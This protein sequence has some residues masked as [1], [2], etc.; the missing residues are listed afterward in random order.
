[1]SIPPNSWRR[2]LATVLGRPTSKERKVFEIQLLLLFILC[3]VLYLGFPGTRELR[4]IAEEKQLETIILGWD[5]VAWFVWLGA[6]PLMLILIHRNP[7][8]GGQFRRSLG[9]LLV[10]SVGLYLL[11]AHMRYFLRLL[12]DFWWTPPPHPMLTFQAYVFN[13]FALLPLDF[14][15]YSGFFA[16]TL[17]VD[18]YFKHRQNAEAAL[19]LQLR[20]ARLQAD[21]TRAELAALRGQLHPHFLFNSFNALAT[22]V[23]QRKNEQAVEI[24]AQLS[25]LLRLAIDRTGLTEIPLEEEIDFIRRYLDL[26]QV[27]FGEKLRVEIEVDPAALD[28]AVPNIVLQPLVE[29]AIKHGISQRT[30]PGTVRLTAAGR[31]GRLRID[32]ANDGPDETPNTAV[33]SGARSPGIGLANARAQLNKLY[34]DDYRLEFSKQTSGVMVVSLDLP[35]RLKPTQDLA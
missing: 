17:S 27:R 3:S 31:A 26:E 18:Y 28:A 14:L 25:A 12:P 30:A 13:A 5:G 33:K 10:G 4:R 34:G 29:N 35:L 20:A 9:R 32:I 16:V 23:R 2:L 21:L 6:A 24:I 1:M 7:L 11:V 8:V 15:T 22:L 19:Q